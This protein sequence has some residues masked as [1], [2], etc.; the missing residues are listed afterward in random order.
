MLAGVAVGGIGLG[1]GVSG[2]VVGGSEV[3]VREAAVGVI[4]EGG[5]MGVLVPLQA[6]TN[7]TRKS[8][9]RLIYDLLFIVYIGSIRVHNIPR[10]ISQITVQILHML[11]HDIRR[12]KFDKQI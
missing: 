2:I 5:D 1:M 12:A 3:C 6:A 9:N 7:N 10:S 4:E 11:L 8:I